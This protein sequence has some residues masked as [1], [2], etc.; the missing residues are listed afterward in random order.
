MISD[1][2]P[3]SISNNWVRLRC[4]QDPCINVT[5]E[6]MREIGFDLQRED[7]FLQLTHNVCIVCFR[8]MNRSE[9][10]LRCSLN[11]NHIFG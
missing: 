1:V 2:S 4:Y 9:G 7:L 10:K 3:Y 11:F 6:Y 8:K 5:V